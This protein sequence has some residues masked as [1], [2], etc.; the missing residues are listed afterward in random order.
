MKT[1]TIILIITNIVV[2][3]VVAI[4]TGSLQAKKYKKEI[5]LLNVTHENRIKELTNEYFHKIEILELEHKHQQE[6]E[7]QKAGNLIVEKLTDK[8]SD[9]FIKQPA[10]Q[11]LIS[12][13]ASQSFLKKKR[14]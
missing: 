1:E 6:L 14:H 10:T 7:T 2:P 9:E 4:I 13:R 3:I 11:K 5:E 12:Q 8:I